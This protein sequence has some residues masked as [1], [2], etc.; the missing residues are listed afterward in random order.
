MFQNC[1]SIDQTRRTARNALNKPI[2]K[3][4]ANQYRSRRLGNRRIYVWF[5][6]QEG[7]P[8]DRQRWGRHRPDATGRLHVSHM[9]IHRSHTSSVLVHL[10]NQFLK[11]MRFPQISWEFSSN[12]FPRLWTESQWGS[13]SHFAFFKPFLQVLTQSMKMFAASLF[14]A[15]LARIIWTPVRSQATWQRNWLDVRRSQ[16]QSPASPSLL[17]SKDNIGYYKNWII[18]DK[19]P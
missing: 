14:A 13:H 12:E 10:H 8:G 1:S 3:S 4:V 6:Q 15:P 5:H 11:Y 7:L 9:H 18:Q 19:I 17:P 2:H 16:P